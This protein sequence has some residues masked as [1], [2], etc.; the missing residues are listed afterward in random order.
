MVRI[1]STSPLPWKYLSRPMSDA[2]FSTICFTFSGC[3]MNSR[4]TERNAATAPDTCDA[5]VLVPLSSR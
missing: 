2:L 4:R 1:R 5:A 3:P